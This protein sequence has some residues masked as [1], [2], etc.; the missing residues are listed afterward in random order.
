MAKPPE[1]APARHANGRFGPGNPGRPHGARGRYSRRVLDK[2]AAHFD[3][4]GNPA[5]DELCKWR[6]TEYVRHMT[7]VLPRAVEMSLPAFG[8]LSASEAEVFVAHAWAAL[9]GERP[10]FEALAALEAVLLAEDEEL[11]R[12]LEEACVRDARTAAATDNTVD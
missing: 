6:T 5:L 7:S 11:I 2:M 4:N 12:D 8:P 9:S 3:V 1:S 10:A